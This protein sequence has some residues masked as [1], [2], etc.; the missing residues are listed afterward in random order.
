MPQST[1]YNIRGGITSTKGAEAGK[2]TKYDAIAE[3]KEREAYQKAKGVAGIG[4]VSKRQ[5]PQYK[6][7][8]DEHIKKWREGRAKHAGQVKGVTG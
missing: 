8:E 6:A 1:E 4:G 3:K 7:G 2:D 5:T